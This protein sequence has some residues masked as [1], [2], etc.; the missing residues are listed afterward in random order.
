MGFL[1]CEAAQRREVIELYEMF[2]NQQRY[3]S[4]SKILEAHPRAQT[5][6]AV[7][8]LRY[9]RASK[10]DVVAMCAFIAPIA[11]KGTHAEWERSMREVEQLFGCMDA[12]GNG[13]IELME[14]L[15]AC[16]GVP[17][18]PKR[19]ALRELFQS[20]D[21]DGNGILD[22]EE[23]S[24]LAVTHDLRPY[25]AGIIACKKEKLS[26]KWLLTKGTVLGSA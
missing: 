19:A 18:L 25:F 14:F 26:T 3:T 7:L 24:Q 5:F 22:K 8:Q 2:T 11:T 13:G 16:D 10:S 4:F 1:V 6:E 23:F 20:A 17:G 9:P 21:A 15:D 12:D